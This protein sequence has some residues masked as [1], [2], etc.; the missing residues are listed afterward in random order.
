MENLALTVRGTLYMPHSKVKYNK[1][2]QKSGP[3]CG[4][5]TMHAPQQ[6]QIQHTKS[7]PCCEGN[8]MHAPQQGQI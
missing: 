7:G 1:H 3:Y 4:G 8:A 5:D 2:V 6:G